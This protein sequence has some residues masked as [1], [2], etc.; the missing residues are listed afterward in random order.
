MGNSNFSY[1]RYTDSEATEV[2]YS[3]PAN[4][5]GEN[6]YKHMAFTRK[7]ESNYAATCA[8]G[9]GNWSEPSA[10]APASALKSPSACRPGET[11]ESSFTTTGSMR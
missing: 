4:R 8:N 10:I 5:V 7:F 1:K 2:F 6:D 9:T 11:A 3:L